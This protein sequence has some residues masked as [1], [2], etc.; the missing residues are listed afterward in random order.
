M[1]QA[2]PALPHWVSDWEPNGT[3]VLPLQQPIGHDVASQTHCPLGLHSSPVGHA[4]QAA[5][6]AP[7][8][9]ALSAEKVTHVVPL[10]QPVQ[11]LLLQDEASAGLSAWAVASTSPGQDP[12]SQVE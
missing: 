5:P 1:P 3:H 11:L 2:A 9:F 4:W 10:Q 6:P 8:T 12:A 7:Q